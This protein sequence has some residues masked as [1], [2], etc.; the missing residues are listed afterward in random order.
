MDT[1]QHVTRI[2]EGSISASPT[3]ISAIASSPV[4]DVMALTGGQAKVISLSCHEFA[5]LQGKNTGQYMTTLVT[6]A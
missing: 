1:S 6:F 4:D 2:L 3:L 5:F